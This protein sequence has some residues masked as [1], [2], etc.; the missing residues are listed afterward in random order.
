MTDIGRGAF[1]KSCVLQV[2]AWPYRQTEALRIS[3]SFGSC[4]LHNIPGQAVGP[5]RRTMPAFSLAPLRHGEGRTVS[6]SEHPGIPDMQ[7]FRQ[8]Y[9]P[10][11]T[12]LQHP[13]RLSKS[14]HLK[15]IP[16]QAPGKHLP[17]F[18]AAC[19][20]FSQIAISA[21]WSCNTVS[22][23]SAILRSDINSPSPLVVS[24]Q[25][26]LL[27]K[28]VKINPSIIRSVRSDAFSQQPPCLLSSA[29]TTAQ[30]TKS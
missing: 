5:P 23:D 25:R 19:A 26:N 24:D 13:A 3:K 16:L 10:G 15:P 12:I 21:T 11:I 9:K 8:N 14:Q 17:F 6:I 7:H 22:L 4:N 27:T 30:S 1:V 28:G 2:V 29:H 18:F 20:L